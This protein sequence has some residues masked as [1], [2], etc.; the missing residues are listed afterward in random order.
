VIYNLA[1]SYVGPV[2]LIALGLLADMPVALAVGLIWCAHIGFDRMLGYGLKY[3]SG[4]AATHLGRLG[5]TD[6]W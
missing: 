6:P 1:H 2:A 5:P 3:T 4:F